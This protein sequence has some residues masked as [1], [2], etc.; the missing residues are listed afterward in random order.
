MILGYLI[1]KQEIWLGVKP[2]LESAVLWCQESHLNPDDIDIYECDGIAEE[3]VDPN[4]YSERSPVTEEEALSFIRQ[5]ELRPHPFNMVWGA[6]RC[7]S[8][9]SLPKQ[10][11]N[12]MNSA[13][14]I[15]RIL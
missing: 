3:K 6:M 15:W 8:K 10:I 7:N 11:E 14:R 5:R 1:E 9:D 4:L 13:P 2:T 12:Y